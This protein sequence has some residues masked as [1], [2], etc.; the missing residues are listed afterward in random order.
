MRVLALAC[1][2][3]SSIVHGFAP[4]PIARTPW[5]TT[6]LRTPTSRSHPLRAGIEG[7]EDSGPSTTCSSAPTPVAL[8][9]LYTVADGRGFRVCDDE[10]ALSVA[11]AHRVADLS[12]AAI[13]D[14]G[15]FYLS[16]G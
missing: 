15:A 5:S 13:A 11:L 12:R 2:L 1:F 10:S 4:L 6:P 7:Q 3:T 8:P 9:P 16:I 14:H